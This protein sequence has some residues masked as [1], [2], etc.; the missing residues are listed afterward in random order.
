[1]NTRKKRRNGETRNREK[2]RKK[3]YFNLTRRYW[4]L[5]F[6]NHISNSCAIP[7]FVTTTWS[8]IQDRTFCD[9]SLFSQNTPSWMLEQS[10]NGLCLWE[11]C[12]ITRP[13]EF[14]KE[15]SWIKHVDFFRFRHSFRSSQ[16][17]W[18][19]VLITIDEVY[20]LPYELPNNLICK[21]L[22]N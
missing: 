10:Q 12:R 4:F 15:Q 6:L 9:N 21:I 14:K 7:N 11:M 13:E 19:L 8:T 16:L 22:E 2:T 1:M 17:K 18:N 20:E 5:E 3:Y